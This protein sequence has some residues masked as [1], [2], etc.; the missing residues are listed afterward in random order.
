MEPDILTYQHAVVG[1]PL[2]DDIREAGSGEEAF[3]EISRGLANPPFHHKCGFLPQSDPLPLANGEAAGFADFAVFAEQAGHPWCCAFAG[4]TTPSNVLKDT[5]DVVTDSE[6]RPCHRRLHLRT[7]DTPRGSSASEE[8]DS[9][10]LEGPSE[11]SE[12]NVSSLASYEDCTDDEQMMDD[13]CVA[14]QGTCPTSNPS[15]KP[16]AF[17]SSPCQSLPPSDSF[18]DFCSAATQQDLG[19]TWAQIKERDDHTHQLLQASFPHMDAPTKCET[20]EEDEKGGIPNLEVLLYLKQLPDCERHTAD[21]ARPG[22][23][24]PHHDL[25]DATGLKFKWGT[26]HANRRLLTCL[27]MMAEPKK[28][29]FPQTPTLGPCNQRNS[30]DQA[31][32]TRS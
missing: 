30:T 12:P 11:D 20:K 15:S 2:D 24:L 5:R 19:E 4:A 3:R 27:G 32:L 8:P 28:E 17:H 7:R 18:A 10:S 31:R 13:M 14:S 22:F 23:Y 6:P 1:P 29:R 9:P 21:G 26:S 16:I 25:C